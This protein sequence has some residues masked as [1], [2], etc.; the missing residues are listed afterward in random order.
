LFI[1][2]AFCRKVEQTGEQIWFIHLPQERHLLL[3]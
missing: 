1:F 3:R 2:L